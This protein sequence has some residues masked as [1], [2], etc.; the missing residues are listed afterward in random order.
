MAGDGDS[1]WTSDLESILSRAEQPAQEK[2]DAHN[3]PC[4]G[5]KRD[6]GEPHYG[7]PHIKHRRTSSPKSKGSCDYSPYGG[8]PRH[9]TSGAACH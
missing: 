5:G 8:G 9:A 7:V 4:N 3:Q 2:K 6:K 1:D